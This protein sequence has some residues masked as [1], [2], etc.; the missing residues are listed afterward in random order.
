MLVR[1]YKKVYIDFVL[2]SIIFVS[3]PF[4]NIPKSFLQMS[5]CIFSIVLEFVVMGSTLL[6][7]ASCIHLIVTIVNQIFSLILRRCL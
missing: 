3:F 6:F 7:D 4:Q 5:S 2:G 1:F